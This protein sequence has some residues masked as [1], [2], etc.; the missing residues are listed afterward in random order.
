M[1]DVKDEP[2]ATKKAGH[3]S[4]KFL[5]LTASNYT[6][7]CMRI[8]ITLKFS[9]TR[10]KKAMVG[11]EEVE[12]GAVAHP[13]EVIEESK[14]VKKF[15]KSLPRKKYIQIVASI[16][17]LLGLNSTSFEDIVGRLKAYEERITE[18]EEEEHEDKNQTS[19]IYEYSD[20][21]A[22]QEQRPLGERNLTTNHGCLYTWEHNRDQR[23]TA[24]STHQANESEKTIVEVKRLGNND[25]III[26]EGD[27]NETGIEINEEEDLEEGGDEV[28]PQLTRSQRVTA[29]PS[30]LDDYIILAEV[31]GERLLMIVMMNEVVYL[32]ERKVNPSTFEADL[33]TMNI[34]YLDNGASNH[35]SGNRLT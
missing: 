22:M 33:D 25:E 34:W 18:D 14:I 7:W 21:F 3:A 8:K 28:Q 24:Y 32:N 17:Q 1:A 26:E 20:V 27:E 9:E 23:C 15:L 13:R 10:D 5:M 30:H 29:K 35:M 31:E 2:T 19:L 16:E 6:V 12:D 11:T 4:I